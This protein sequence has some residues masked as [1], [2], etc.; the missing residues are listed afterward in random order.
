MPR[1]Q[2]KNFQ[3]L[4]K[5]KT[6][7]VPYPQAVEMQGLG[8]KEPCWRIGNPNGHTMWKWSEVDAEQV[9]VDAEQV[10]NTEYGPN[11]VEI[12]THQ[13]SFNWFREKYNLCGE[14]YTVNMGAI[15]YTFQ[16]RDL[17][18]EDVTHNNFEAYA[19][20]YSGTFNTYEAAELAC[21]DTL[22]QIAKT[23]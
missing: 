12:P 21:L 20:G 2:V 16:I 18:S 15:D 6:L 7:F 9:T 4:S 17:Y 8:F 11:W 23:R 19:G 22:I 3:N 5:M 13:Q 1:T 10:L 14:I